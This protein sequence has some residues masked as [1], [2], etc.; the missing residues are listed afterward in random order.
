MATDPVCG[1]FV[2]EKPDSIQHTVDGRKYYFCSTQCLNEFTEP[3]R[4]LRKLRK[5][6]AISIALT[7]PI[8]ILTLPH[9]FPSQLEDLIPLPMETS[10]YVMLALAT[11]I[12]F[13][14]GWRFYKGMWDGIKA[15]ASNMD[16]L[17]A[18]G[19][20][21]AYVYSSAVTI[22]PGYF[23]FA[24]VYFETAAIIITLI[25][26]GRLLE[27]RTKEKAS[28]AVRKLMDLQPQMAKV[29]REGNRE[30]EE[31]PVEQVR[32]GDL[33]VIRPGERVPVDAV[34]IDGV[35][36][37]DESAITGES[38]PVDKSRGSEV[39]GATINQSG[40]LTVKA[41]KV[42]QDTVL[43]QI[44][45]LVENARMGKAPMQRMVDQVAKYFVPVVIAVAVGAGLGWYFAGGA[46]LTYSVLAFVS[47]IIIACPCALGIATPA[48]LMMGAGKGAENGILFKSGEYLEIARKINTVVFDKTGTLTEG[49]PSVTDIVD[50]SGGIGENE[51]LR[52]AA[53]AELGSEH[54]L[55]QAVVRKAKESGLPVSNPESFEAVTGHGLR[56]T[57]AGHT[58][59]IGNR[60]LMH[61]NGIEVGSRVDSLLSR[62][63]HEGKTAT[64]VSIGSILSG[65]IAMADTIKESANEAVD[66]LKNKMGIEVIM[67]TGDNEKTAK[68][69]A[70]RLSIDR[71]IAQ[72]LP[73]QKEEVIAKLRSEEG[74]VVAM[75]GDGINDAP[76]LA[77]ADLG[78]AIG[79]G[80]DVAKE[81][82]G[83][84][85][86]KD[87]VRDVATALELGKKTVSKIK[88]NLFWA[89]AYNTGLIP[90]A[91]GALVP[92]LGLSV[93]G[94]LPILAGAAMALSSVT[95]V[96]NSILLG[97]YR[98]RYAAAK[99]KE[100]QVYSNRELKS[101]YKP[102]EARAT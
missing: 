71:V 12:Q 50:M 17:I 40:L 14:I 18:L 60:K 43:S 79:S 11:P 69:I 13:W 58:I 57:Y 44:I 80:T 56:A 2:E 66:S 65:I 39:I 34:V 4:E 20:S 61:E 23:P 86:I 51:L 19:T 76:A 88:Q 33:L 55:G 64:L 100:E 73:Q 8:V 62:L 102:S 90:I 48:A 59:L 78:I 99:P 93:F 81:T 25:L 91:G 94:W 70:S 16:T 15:R 98:P 89:F 31:I 97:R 77:R 38:I 1:M 9:M 75:V 32:E 101:V 6:V 54:P 92:F 21:A 95:V 24:S 26:V 82:G 68:A 45:T 85:L 42:G 46:G 30:E 27:T 28:S 47:V 7:I 37:I 67:L 83:I 36:S 96:G 29:I 3:E 87:D 41:T 52:L 49:K 35:S 10:N 22:A 5:H 74:R 84:I 53:I 72:V 63:E